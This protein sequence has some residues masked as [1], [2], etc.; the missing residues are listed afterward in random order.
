METI[1][2]GNP[3]LDE[4]VVVKEK[5]TNAPA[6]ILYND[7]V[8]SFDHVIE[9]L[10]QYCG[11]AYEQAGQCASIVHHNGKCDVK[12][13]SYEELRPIYESLLDNHLSAKIE[14]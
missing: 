13:G 1:R 4:E 5:T 8:N 11:H 9:C 14:I 12:H 10:M 6:I 3:L 7:D 2:S